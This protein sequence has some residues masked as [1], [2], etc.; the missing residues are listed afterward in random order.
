[1]IYSTESSIKAMSS[2]SA[3]DVAFENALD[4][5]DISH[6]I[7][8]GEQAALEA[9]IH[10]N[11]TITPVFESQIHALQENVISTVAEKIKTFF[12]NLWKRIQAVWQRIKD[13]FTKKE[14][15]KIEDI[16]EKL[17]EKKSTAKSDTVTLELYDI[18]TAS[19]R[20][21]AVYS[22][23]NELL[24][25]IRSA[26]IKKATIVINDILIGHTEVIKMSEIT[27]EIN[28]GITETFQKIYPDF[29]KSKTPESLRT[30][31]LGEKQERTVSLTKCLDTANKIS[32]KVLIPIQHK[33]EIEANDDIKSLELE[34]TKSSKDA[35]T[36]PV[37]EAICRGSSMIA[38]FILSVTA[39][40]LP[41][42]DTIAN[43]INKVAEAK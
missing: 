34:A 42:I 14:G 35:D 25:G 41:I 21:N 5:F 10:N 36:I 15:K 39:S 20:V 9:Y 1:M 43:D 7:I 3:S 22:T 24:T 16:K 32:A 19:N 11:K 23:C 18:E 30:Y 13:F 29:D 33:I 37:S 27:D 28:R 2:L 26:A 40:M 4:L 31:V 38:T 12:R 8:N 17:E 6:A